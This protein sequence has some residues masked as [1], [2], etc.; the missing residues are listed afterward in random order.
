MTELL[1]PMQEMMETQID[2]LA[3]RMDIHQ[4]EMTAGHQEITAKMRAWRKEMKADREAMVACLGKAEATDL[5]ANPEEKESA[6]VHEEAVVKT[7]RALKKR[8]GDQH[9]AVGCRRQLQ[10]LT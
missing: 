10:K 4:A 3:F 7:V 5:E 6:A 1:K 2:S 8:Y 9:L